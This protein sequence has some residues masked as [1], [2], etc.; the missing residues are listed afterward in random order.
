MGASFIYFELCSALPV[1][2]GVA[3]SPLE[4]RK[5]FSASIMTF[6]QFSIGKLIRR[7]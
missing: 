6:T 4:W 1:V 2:M 5:V 3:E 7:N